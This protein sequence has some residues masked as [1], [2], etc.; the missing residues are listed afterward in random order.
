MYLGSLCRRGHDHEGTGQSLRYAS[1]A[2]SLCYKLARDTRLSAD[3]TKAAHYKEMAKQRRERNKEAR[4][5]QNRERK[6]RN[7]DAIE[8]RRRE[9]YFLR[10]EE[11]LKREALKREKHRERVR[12]TSRE[13]KRRERAAKPEEVR[14]QAREF[15]R[16]NH[17]RVRLRNRVNQALRHQKVRKALTVAEYGI[18][19]AAIA[20]HL[21]PCPGDP[22]EWHIDHIR[23][24]S[25]F[26]LTDA[27]QVKVAFAPENHQWLLAVENL[28]KH[29]KYESQEG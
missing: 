3:A 12:H 14:K 20:A 8:A 22:S 19:V 4:R 7:R 24:L 11:S 13:A 25:S 10:H 2:C 1:G 16:R 9:L 6:E 27:E 17:I 15:Y 28:R 29:A 26:N 21:G 5:I 18:D 23:P